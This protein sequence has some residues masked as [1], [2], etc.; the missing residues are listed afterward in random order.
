[1]DVRV[2]RIFNTFGPMMHMYDGKLI[3]L[4]FHT[5]VHMYILLAFCI[6]MY[7]HVC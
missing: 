2:A 5:T 7:I 3:I 4:C 1:M 6:Y